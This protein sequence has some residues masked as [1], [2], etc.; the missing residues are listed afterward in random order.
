MIQAQGLLE[1]M[2]STKTTASEPA[3]TSGAP[4]PNFRLPSLLDEP[5]D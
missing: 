4:N 3:S 5:D 1:D 2:N